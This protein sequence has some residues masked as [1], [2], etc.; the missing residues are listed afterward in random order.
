MYTCIYMSIIDVH[1]YML[2]PFTHLPDLHKYTIVTTIVSLVGIMRESSLA[3]VIRFRRQTLVVD[4]R[5]V[6]AWRRRRFERFD[7]LRRWLDIQVARRVILGLPVVVGRRVGY[8]RVCVAINRFFAIKLFFKKSH[9][10][11]QIQSL[12]Q[13]DILTEQLNK[14]SDFFKKDMTVRR[15]QGL[16]MSV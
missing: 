16:C 3:D 2:C 10:S 9:C 4:R 12:Y 14:D 8:P 15:I 6:G 1:M 7:V 11:I 5:Q 13:I